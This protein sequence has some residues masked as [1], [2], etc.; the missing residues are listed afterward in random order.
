MDIWLDDVDIHLS[1]GVVMHRSPQQA[2]ADLQ[3][4]KEQAGF[5]QSQNTEERQDWLPLRTV[6]ALL[7]GRIYETPNASSSQVASDCGCSC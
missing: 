4:I 2:S 6:P 5:I 3:R 1:W 7:D